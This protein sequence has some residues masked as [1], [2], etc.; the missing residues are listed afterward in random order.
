MMMVRLRRIEFLLVALTGLCVAAPAVAQTLP[1]PDA[2]LNLPRDLSPWGMFMAADIIVKAVMLGLAFASVLT[3]TIWL[4][5][6]IELVSAR[7]RLRGAIATLAK[8]RSFDDA[9]AAMQARADS[10]GALMRA[11]AEELRLSAG[12]LA[13][14]KERIASRLERIEAASGR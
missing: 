3:W 12:A 11:A 5:K 4:A 8:A 6:A 1:A 2:V 7:R 10:V 9:A 13:D 14:V